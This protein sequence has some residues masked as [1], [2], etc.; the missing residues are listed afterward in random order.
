M[1][2]KEN[3]EFYN[4]FY[5]KQEVQINIGSLF[6]PEWVEGEVVDISPKTKGLRRLRDRLLGLEPMIVRVNKEAEA[7][8]GIEVGAYKGT[9]KV[10][11]KSVDPRAE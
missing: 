5:N 10:R 6:S 4:K 3:P 7:W 2:G 11:P 8:A 1:G 9:P